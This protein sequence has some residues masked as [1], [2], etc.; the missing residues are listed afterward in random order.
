MGTIIREKREEMQI[1]QT[2]L[3]KLVG[4]SCKSISAYE[5]GTRVPS[6]KV[7][8]K[9]VKIL[10]IPVNKIRKYYI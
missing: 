10:S 5:L 6:L 4:V 2:E 1:S 7:V 8:I 9:L 3:S